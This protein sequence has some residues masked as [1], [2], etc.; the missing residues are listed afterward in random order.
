MSTS[1]VDNV[2]ECLILAA[3][4]GRG[5]EAYCVTDG[6]DNRLKKVLNDLLE[7]RGVPPIRRSATFGVALH[8]AAIMEG[9]LFGIRPKP[10]IT[11]QILR[12]IGQDNLTQIL[13]RIAPEFTLKQM[14]KM[15]PSLGL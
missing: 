5:G 14:A 15:I 10:P 4:K 3:E 12:M 9:I 7:T 2:V 1:H 8:V 13:S 6:A 11:R